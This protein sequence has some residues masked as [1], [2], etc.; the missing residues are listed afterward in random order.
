MAALRQGKRVK[1]YQVK[2]QLRLT[3]LL[4]VVAAAVVA[5]WGWLAPMDVGPK[6][7][8]DAPAAATLPELKEFEVIWT[9]DL[10]PQAGPHIAEAPAPQD[11]SVPLRLL[12]TLGGTQAL[13]ATP[14]GVAQAVSVGESVN[15]I[16]IVEVG[17]GEM[18]VR[19]NG[20]LARVVKPPESD[21]LQ[22]G[23]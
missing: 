15:G 17:A 5:S 21:A 20:K 19:H 7:S 10:H 4:L 3:T 8:A 2:L 1:P 23:G 22:G 18:T 9:A 12:G 6:R 16:E 14:D 11:D 13:V